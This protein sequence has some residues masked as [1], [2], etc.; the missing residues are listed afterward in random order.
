M[1]FILKRLAGA[2]CD[3]VERLVSDRD[4]KACLFAQSEVQFA[5]QRTTSGE[6]HAT[7]HD[8]RRKVG[9][10]RFER[11]HDSF[12]DLLHGFRQ[13]LGHLRLIDFGFLGHAV[14][15]VA[16]A[17]L[18]RLTAPVVGHACRADGGLDPLR[19]GFADQ[20]VMLTAQIA[21]DGFVHPV[22]THA[23]RARIN[24]VT[25]RK[26]GNFSGTAANIDNHVPGRIG[27][28]HARANGRSD[29]FGDQARATCTG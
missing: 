14:Q 29:R 5:E 28:R 25:E 22:A 21:D 11:S 27:D 6:H 1:F 19:R 13:S 9:W 12:A 8:I 15:Q 7:V 18:H 2:K 10:G 3:T 4:R 16:P 24:D 17:D 23:Y 20:K 26:Y